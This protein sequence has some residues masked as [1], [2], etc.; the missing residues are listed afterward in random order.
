MI[1][2]QQI[3]HPT[4]S[5]IGAMLKEERGVFVRVVGASDFVWNLK[6]FLRVRSVQGFLAERHDRRSVASLPAELSPI[7][8]F[9]EKSPTVS[10]TSEN[11]SVASAFEELG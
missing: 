6:D 3:L 7:R 5:F 8:F 2:T 11:R 1:H 10:R 9:V 4:R